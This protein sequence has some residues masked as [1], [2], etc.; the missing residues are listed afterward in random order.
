MNQLIQQ[1]LI[2]MQG[3]SMIYI[4][5]GNNNNYSE[6]YATELQELLDKNNEETRMEE[7]KQICEKFGIE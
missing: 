7:R 5:C 3:V 1:K 6:K 2:I 4:R